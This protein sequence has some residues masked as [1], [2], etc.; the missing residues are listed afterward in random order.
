MQQVI[1][2]HVPSQYH[3]INDFL[4]GLSAA[5]LDAGFSPVSIDITSY[6]EAVLSAMLQQAVMA[7][8]VNAVGADLYHRFPQLETISFY[9]LL[10]DHPLHLLA[11]FYGRPLKLLCV[12]KAHVQFC[13]ALGCSAYFF[14]HA[15]WPARQE[16]TEPDISVKQGILFPATYMSTTKYLDEI[17][18]IFPQILPLLQRQDINDINGLLHHLGFM[19]ADKEQ[20][21]PLNNA[22]AKLLSLCDLY[23]RALSRQ[24][25]IDTCAG[26]NIALTVVGNG[27]Q[28]AAQHALHRYLPAEPFPA[29]LSR[30]AASKYVLHHNP[31]FMLGQ[32][33]RLVYSMLLG[34][35]VLC[36][37]NDYLLQRYGQ[38][39]SIILYQ[40]VA[41][42]GELSAA[43]TPLVYQQVAET[44]RRQVLNEDTWQVRLAALLRTV[45]LKLQPLL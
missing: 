37:Q 25:L 19:Q 5:V 27:W 43:V 11:R 33:E 36:H 40:Q 18:Q 42:L 7:L 13:L 20:A 30:I 15:V 41:D 45:E 35:P 6:D 38:T 31:G 17:N 3:V 23:L 39:G 1:I 34:T 22:T 9:T 14:P 8:S 4:Q 10:V 16:L 26:H 24:Q 29:L 28:H 44:A 21:L 12:D 2:F 32:H